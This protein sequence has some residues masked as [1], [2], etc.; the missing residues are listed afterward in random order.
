MERSGSIPA[1]AQLPYAMTAILHAGFVLTG[2]V[3]TLLG[4]ILPVL[5]SQWS[6]S[7]AQAGY[8]FVAQFLGSTAGVVLSGFLISR[9]GIL[10]TLVAGF[11]VMA[12]G[13]AALGM[14]P[15]PEC[16]VAVFCYGVA[17]GLIIPT[18]NVLISE[19]NPNRPA[20][21]LSIL[22]LAWSI[23]AVVSPPI[24]GLL[25]VNGDRTGRLL[26]LAAL[27]GLVA[28]C[29]TQFQ[30]VPKISGSDKNLVDAFGIREWRRP[31]AVVFGALFFLYVGT[32]NAVGGWVATYA[33]RLSNEPGA[34]W[35]LAPSLFWAALLLGRALTPAVLRYLIDAKLVVAGLLMTCFGV[36]G[37]LVSRTLVGVFV[38][39]SLAGL[40]LSSV[41]P[42]TIAMLMRCFGSTGSRI[43]GSMFALAGLGGATLPWL[44]GFLSSRF[45]N[46][47]V[48]LVVPLVGTLVMVLLQLS[49]Y[50]SLS[51]VANT[52]NVPD[53]FGPE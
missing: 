13:V 35:E 42:I 23:G 1:A 32:E 50:A 2:I 16:V 6:L 25:I 37:L 26:G 36:T 27:L 53:I 38:G 20:A 33:N 12:V 17:L 15:W 43:A 47:G 11:S 41:F 21:A 22:N 19:M 18:T 8:L 3:T 44:V 14:S 45:G 31:L 40:G 49:N 5:S 29:L 48:G 46:L 4:P 28:L 52:G 24:V 39:V 7:D 9:L 51:T 30:I 34:R 10:R